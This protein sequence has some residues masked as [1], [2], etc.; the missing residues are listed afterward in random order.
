MVLKRMTVK[1]R[2]VKK[3]DAKFLYDLLNERDPIFNISHKK[4]PAYN[5]HFK[6]VLS[7][8]YSKWYIIYTNGIKAGSAY[9]SKQNEIGIHIKK[10][11]STEKIRQ[12]VLDTLIKK[13]PKKRYL[14]N[15]NPNN[16]KTIRFFKK[17]GFSL[18]QYTFE[19]Q[20]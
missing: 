20:R 2:P 9:L 5:E 18:I 12:E 7:K 4:M 3:S 8:P 14:A 16:K 17:N 13:N 1:L 10:E 6:F 19:L 15:I 11:F